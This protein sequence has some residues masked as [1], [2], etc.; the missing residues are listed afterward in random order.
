LLRLAAGLRHR[1]HLDYAELITGFHKHQLLD[2][3]TTSSDLDRGEWLK[4]DIESELA[5]QV[6]PTI[7]VARFGE[8]RLT[9]T[10]A[11]VRNK[12]F[13]RARGVQVWAPP[14]SLIHA[15]FTGTLS[16]T[17]D[18]VRVKDGGITLTI[19]D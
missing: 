8:A 7:A 1:Q 5:E 10:E 2:F 18:T 3:S 15:P 13:T 6:S 9:R 11:D 17:N 14:G 4:P 12:A 16:S 19:I